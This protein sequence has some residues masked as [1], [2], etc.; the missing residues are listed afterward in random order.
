M[1]DRG[2]GEWRE[3]T[4]ES[5][6][7]GSGASGASATGDGESSVGGTDGMTGEVEDDEGWK[8]VTRRH[9]RGGGI[10]VRARR[11]GGRGIQAGDGDGSVVATEQNTGVSNRTDEARRQRA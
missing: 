6:G 1:E 3:D 10:K 4:E 5:S 7:N 9:G 2:G 8:Q 11:K